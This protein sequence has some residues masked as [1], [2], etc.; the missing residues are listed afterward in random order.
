MIDDTEAVF[1]DIGGVL[2][3]LR[4][5]RAGHR[6]FVADLAAEHGLDADR[7]LATWRDVLGEY[8]RERRGTE[9][10]S[11]LVG[12]RRA[13]AAAVGA[14]L[15]DDE[16]RPPFDRVTEGSLEPVDGAREA[17][18]ALA[19][20][21]YLGVISDIDTREAERILGNF[22]LYDAFDAVTTSEAV[23]RTKPDPAIFATA[24][25]I[26]GVDPDRSAMIG[27]RYHNDM[28]GGS[29]AGLRT[30]AFGGSAANG[31]SYEDDERD[32][33]A[34]DAGDDRDDGNTAGKEKGERTERD[35]DG[36][37]D[38]RIADPR[39]VLGIVGLDRPD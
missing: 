11:A 14:D 30:I 24:V 5:V 17:V 12:Y 6:R 34:E 32:E 4:S 1:F 29:W 39:D 31:P 20:E 7:A 9:F 23:G 35:P 15:P 2:L 37:V 26:A 3:D 10:R 21:V 16:W 25:G 19:D 38:Y 27:D 33:Q 28:R 22:K 8:F 36:V 13:V 18:D